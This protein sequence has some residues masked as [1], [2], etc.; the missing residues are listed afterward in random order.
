[1]T[2][3]T[4][5]PL[6]RR[7]LAFVAA[8]SLLGSE[9]RASDAVTAEIGG[10]QSKPTPTIASAPFEYQ[11]IAGRW[12]A[13]ETL[14]LSASVRLTHDFAGAPTEGTVLRTGSD[15]VWQGTVGVGHD[16]SKHV[17]IGLD[18]S[19]SPPSRR[20]IVSPLS[21]GTSGA[22]T[23]L[24]S[25]MRANSWNAGATFDLQYDTFDDEAEHDVDLT[26]DASV[27]YTHFGSSQ[28]LAAVEEPGGVVPVETLATRCTGQATDTCQ[29]YA[30]AA[31]KTT[32]SLEQLRLGTTFTTTLWDRT[33]IGADVSYYVYDRGSPGDAG[34]FTGFLTDRAGRD[35]GA[36]ATWGA[37]MPVLA[38]RWSL[39]PEL[40][41]RWD[42]ITVRA[43][44]QFASYAVVPSEIGHTVGGKV[45]LLI[46]KWRPYLT[47]NV[48]EDLAGGSAGA[49]SWTIGAGLQRTL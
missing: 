6:R 15:W 13:A 16:V 11:K 8:T 4:L 48:R 28:V 36:T 34:F 5:R 44:Y 25:S 37:G 35:T 27:S 30:D 17:A 24:D 2:R 47:G 26:V 20:D 19:G 41:Q 22:A 49:S 1:M 12:Q 38:P 43:Y 32:A 46:G 3:P 14:S 9:A 7:A 10:G 33:E 45:T 21:Y 39:R 42:W 29:A 18:L 23:T 40:G 31:T